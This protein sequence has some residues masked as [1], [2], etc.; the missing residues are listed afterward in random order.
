MLALLGG[1]ALSC[2]SDRPAP[3]TGGTDD[4]PGAT[5]SAPPELRCTGLYADWPSRTIRTDVRAYTPALTFWSDGA[6]KRRW[7]YLPDGA[8][9]TSDMD[10]W[11]F[12]AGTRAWKELSLGG[13]VIETRFFWKATDTQ[14]IRTTY[15]WSDDGASATRKDDGV[16]GAG[17]TSYEV[18]STDKC[19]QCHRGHRDR[20]L[21]VEAVNLGLPGAQGVTLAGLAAEGRLSAPPAQATLAL[22]EDATHVAAPALGWLHVNCGTIC[23]SQSPD[24]QAAGTGLRL[25]LGFAEVASGQSVAELSLYHSA[26]GG[27]ATTPRWSSLQRIV[28]GDPDD[29]LVVILASMRGPDQMPPIVSHE[30]DEEGVAALRTWIAALPGG[31]PIP[32]AGTDGGEPPDAGTEDA[33]SPPDAPAADAPAT[34]DA[35]PADAPAPPDGGAID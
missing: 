25:R 23:H 1:V 13:R 30:V 11:R 2:S 15:V 33:A 8:I 16:V 26:V 20:L 7:L 19:D 28:P 5:N 17:G 10:E 9:D 4:C 35:A 14:W 34:P 32:D 27:S 31:N 6:E 3:P 22:P 12:P 21:G 18:P 24:A 29:S